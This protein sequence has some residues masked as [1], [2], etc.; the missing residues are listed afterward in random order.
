[1][2]AEQ[3]T[4]QFLKQ[5]NV[6]RMSTGTII[7]IYRKA[8]ESLNAS[9]KPIGLFGWIAEYIGAFQDIVTITYLI[10]II[11]LYNVTD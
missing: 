6:Q 2:S 5:S 1:M 11:L 3:I 8:G 4:I 7:I 10:E 9:V